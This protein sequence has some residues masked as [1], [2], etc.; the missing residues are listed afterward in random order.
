MASDGTA[1]TG[2]WF[3]GQK[4]FAEG[5]AET[6]AAKTQPVFDEAMRWLDGERI[7]FGSAYPCYNMEQAVRDVERFGFSEE[8]KE[9]F[10]HGNAEKLLGTDLVRG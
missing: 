3:D 10:F 9:K 6:A 4:Y 8:H 1:L 7:L 5:L 2:L